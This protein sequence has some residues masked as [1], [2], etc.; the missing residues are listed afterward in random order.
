MMTHVE[1]ITLI[2]KLNSKLQCSG[3]VY[4]IIVIQVYLQME[5]TIIGTADFGLTKQLDEK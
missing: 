5:L 2:V 3:Q 4:V 1:G